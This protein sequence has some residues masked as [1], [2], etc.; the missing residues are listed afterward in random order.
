MN[1]QIKIVISGGGTGGHLFP[2]LAIRDEINNRYPKSSIHYIGSKFGIEK[3][4]IPKKNIS[5][6]LLPIRGFQRNMNLGSF[7]KNILLPLRVFSSII[8]VK[9]LFDEINPNLVIG[10]GGYA[11]AIPL[12]EGINRGIPTLIQEQ[13][14]YP[15]VT[16]RWF[17]KQANKVCIAFEDAKKFINNKSVL[18]GNPIRKEI[19]KGNKEKAL[20]E[21]GF[22]QNKKTLFVFGG[23]QGS[24]YLNQMMEKILPSLTISNIQVIWQTGKDLYQNYSH[25]QS[26][27][28]KVLP[29][30]ENMA[31]A[32]ALSDLV[33]SRSGAIT[34]SELT[35]CGKPSILVP[36][37]N[38]AADHQIKNANALVKS[39]AAC[40]LEEKNINP[41][42]FSITIQN[43]LLDDEQLKSMSKASFKLG[44]P[45][46]TSDIVD[47][48]IAL[49]K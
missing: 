6:S 3:D 4:V 2:A 35:I 18:S 27:M 11:A 43:L 7:G 22:N 41:K 39:G 26:D 29:F 45:K 32:Y 21:Y 20:K 49:I 1:D 24:L 25:N 16:T 5:H 9:K 28:T 47:E 34:C 30:I 48:A 37:S 33:M 42:R 31:N 8:K 36:L 15:G 40:M 13:N 19:S 46:A 23:S 10:T 44:K 38:S 12:R 14:S 17:S